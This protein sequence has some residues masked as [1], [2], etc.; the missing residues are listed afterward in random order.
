MKL[1][2]EIKTVK[3]EDV[4]PYWRNPRVNAFAVDAVKK[5]IEKYGFNQPLVLD[6]KMVIVA[7]HTRYKAL[8][9]LGVEEVPVIILE[10][11]SAKKAK[12]YRIADNKSGEYSEWDF[13]RLIPELRELDDI[14]DFSAM[15][16]DWNVEAMVAEAVSQIEVTP[17]AVVEKGAELAVQFEKMGK[18]AQEDYVEIPCS[19]CGESLYVRRSDLEKR[20]KK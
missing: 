4:K 8:L 13:G 17:E 16:P 2:T 19:H 18:N 7:G 15:F 11:L 9:Q 14:A 20:F 6:K 1:K 5:S 12:E 10:S 3:M